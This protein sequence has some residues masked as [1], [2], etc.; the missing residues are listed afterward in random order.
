M[1]QLN[2]LAFCAYFVCSADKDSGSNADTQ[3]A[4]AVVSA[5]Q[6]GVRA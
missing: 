1:N 3:R 5:A 4:V 2:K 6:V